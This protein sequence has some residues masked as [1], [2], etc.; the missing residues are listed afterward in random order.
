MLNFIGLAIS[1]LNPQ[2]FL[3]N[4]Q[5]NVDTDVPPSTPALY[6]PSF[7][8][9]NGLY[10]VIGVL[11][12][13]IGFEFREWSMRVLGRFFTLK[14]GISEGHYLVDTGPYRLLRHPSYTGIL[15]AAFH[16]VYL[17]VVP[18]FNEVV[19]PLL[20]RLLE[21]AVQNFNPESYLAQSMLELVAI[22]N[23]PFVFNLIGPAITISTYAVYIYLLLGMR[24]PQ[25][26][27]MLK[28]NFGKEWDKFAANRARIIPYIY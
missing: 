16:M 27:E 8:N 6:A 10:D 17:T 9:W 3:S 2:L 4:Q 7:F 28:K 15:L 13:V 24:V 20:I 26:E 1:Q 22:L 19:G 23:D 14:L 5:V 11:L 21:I 12:C 18:T 25:E